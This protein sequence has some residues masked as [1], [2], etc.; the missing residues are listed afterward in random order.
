MQ[1]V[2]NTFGASLKRPGDRFVIRAGPNR[3][4]AAAAKV[5]SIL[6]TPAGRFS[7]DVTARSVVRNFRN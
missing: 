2:I 6:I 4:K 5:Q 1:L 3:L 7:S